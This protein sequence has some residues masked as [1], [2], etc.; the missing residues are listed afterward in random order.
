MQ[1]NINIY[2]H[3]DTIFF[4]ALNKESQL[5]FK[6][7]FDF[8]DFKDVETICNEFIN[9]LRKIIVKPNISSAFLIKNNVEFQDDFVSAYEKQFGTITKL[10]A[11]LN[12]PDESLYD[13]VKEFL[14]EEKMTCLYNK[15]KIDFQN[16]L[17]NFVKSIQ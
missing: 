17:D 6:K 12:L 2:S 15:S 9:E 5:V 11:T 4:G 14:T 8:S 1:L 3:K 7:S 16:E 13:I 10:E